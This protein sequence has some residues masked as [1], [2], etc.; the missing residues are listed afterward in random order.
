MLYAMSRVMREEAKEHGVNVCVL[1]P[2]FINT[3]ILDGGR[4]GR[5]KITEAQA[6]AMEQERS[7]GFAMDVDEFAQQAWHQIK[8]NQA[9]IIVPGVWRLAWWLYRLFPTTAIR[10][11]QS[12]A[13]KALSD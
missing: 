4:Y 3:P 5:M 2:G 12:R 13:R 11:M 10:F 6:Q 9:V 1:C 8:R 7:K